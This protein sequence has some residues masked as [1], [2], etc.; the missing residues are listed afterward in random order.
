MRLHDRVVASNRGTRRGGA[1]RTRRNCSQIRENPF[2]GSR[3]KKRV[4]KNGPVSRSTLHHGRF[5]VRYEFGQVVSAEALRL[6]VLLKNT[7]VV[8][9]GAY[10]D[11]IP[12]AWELEFIDVGQVSNMYMLASRRSVVLADVVRQPQSTLLLYRQP[13]IVRVILWC[14]RCHHRVIA[15]RKRSM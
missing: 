15:D 14:S 11:P 9:D 13:C 2:L 5:S 7:E 8:E 10:V 6:V 3:G 4:D 12:D 1:I